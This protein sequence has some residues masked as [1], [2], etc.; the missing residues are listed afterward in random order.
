[1]K[2]V[3][4]VTHLSLALAVTTTAMLAV[5]GC[6]KKDEPPPPMPT[7][8]PAET[9]APPPATVAP[10]VAQIAPMAPAPGQAPASLQ[11]AIGIARP[12]MA[13]S[14]GGADA[15]ATT[16]MNYWL[17]KS[18]PWAQ[19]E[20]V[21]QTT[22]AAFLA[23]PDAER[24]KRICGQGNIT[25]FSQ[26]S[27]APKQHEATLTTTEGT[28]AVGAVMDVTGMKQGG[29]GRFCGIATGIQSMTDASG[30]AVRAIRL[31]GMFDTPANRGGGGTSGGPGNLRACCQALQQNSVSMPPPNNVYAAAA[32]NYCF[33]VV[34]TS[35]S[36][37]ASLAAI[38]GMMRGAPVPAVCK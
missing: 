13:D 16:L 35:A 9:V 18:Y 22:G 12:Q 26:V 7:S 2:F 32:A 6:S 19:L 31:T 30:A 33:G 10:T 27:A 25:A 11:E 14:T 17:Q 8:T 34:A 20:A 1:M 15:G 29:A 24:G 3:E 21:P 37:D 4:T 36:K 23:A 5:P 38:R 28:L